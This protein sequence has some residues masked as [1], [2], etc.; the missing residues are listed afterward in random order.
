LRVDDCQEH[1]GKAGTAT[2]NLAPKLSQ[3]SLFQSEYCFQCRE[4]GRCLDVYFIAA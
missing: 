1:S 4:R 3:F 2:L